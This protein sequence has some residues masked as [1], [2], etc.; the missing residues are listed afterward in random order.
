MSEPLEGL[1]ND[2]DRSLVD[3]TGKNGR[4]STKY[5]LCPECGNYAVLRCGEVKRCYSSACDEEDY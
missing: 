3:D 5:E 1:V 2:G 4:D